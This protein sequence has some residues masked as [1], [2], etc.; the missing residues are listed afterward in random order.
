S[1]LTQDISTSVLWVNSKPHMITLDYTIHVPQAT[2]QNLPEVSKFRLSYYPHRL[3]SFKGLL[4]EAFNG[5]MEYNA[6]G[7]FKTYIPGQSLLPVTSI[8]VLRGVKVV[9][10]DWLYWGGSLSQHVI[11]QIKQKQRELRETHW[12]E[13]RR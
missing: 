5:N 1:D 3:E 13:R 6:F 10:H 12:L 9:N 7:D 8:H 2:L 11:G 4:N